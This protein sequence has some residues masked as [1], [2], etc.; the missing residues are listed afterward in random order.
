MHRLQ[1]SL[2]IFLWLAIVAFLAWSTLG[3]L[4][5]IDLPH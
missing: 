3:G 4:L 2:G 1:I 5:V